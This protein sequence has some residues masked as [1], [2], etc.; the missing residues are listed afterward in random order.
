MRWQITREE[1]S[2]EARRESAAAAAPFVDALQRMRAIEE[3]ELARA[4]AKPESFLAAGSELIAKAE[5]RMTAALVSPITA[6]LR[7]TTRPPEEATALFV[8]NYL[9]DLAASIEE[10][11]KAPPEEL[12]G[13][14]AAWGKNRRLPTFWELAP[15]EAPAYK[16]RVRKP[17]AAT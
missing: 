2:E 10:I 13:V 1:P 7:E 4:A 16:F 5:P 9:A 12:A 17:A 14:V 8:K 11:A 3:K 15:E 6:L